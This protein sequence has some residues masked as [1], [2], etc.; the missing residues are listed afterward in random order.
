VPY[1]APDA[2]PSRE[3]E[4]EILKDDAEWLKQQLDAIGQR[5][6]ELSQE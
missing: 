6:D 4:V 2:P 5:M 3:Q 1:G